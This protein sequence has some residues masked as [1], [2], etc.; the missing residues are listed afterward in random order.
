M[1]RKK[2]YSD[3]WVNLF[4]AS[5]FWVG[6]TIG[7][8]KLLRDTTQLGLIKSI[9][10]SGLTGFVFFWIVFMGFSFPFQKREEKE[11]R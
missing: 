4:V 11:E 8:V 10:Y 2:R 7:G 3:I 5:I 9:G 1:R 6:I